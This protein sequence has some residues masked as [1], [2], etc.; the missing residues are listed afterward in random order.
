M[1]QITENL[2]EVN[3]SMINA[4]IN[5]LRFDK[6][7][8]AT[9]VN[10]LDEG[11]YQVFN[12]KVKYQAK[13]LNDAKFLQNDQVYV[14]IKEGDYSLEKTIIGKYDISK[15]EEQI[16]IYEDPFD[17]LAINQTLTVLENQKNK[18]DWDNENNWWKQQE[19][20]SFSITGLGQPTYFG[21]NISLETNS[22]FTKYPE[23]SFGLIVDLI[24]EK[25]ITINS[26]SIESQYIVGN[27]YNLTSD[28]KHKNIY[29]LPSD[30]NIEKVKS[31]T[32]KPFVNNYGDSIKWHDI[33]LY[34]G[35]DNKDERI[36][37]SNDKVFIDTNTGFKMYNTT[38]ISHE[39]FN[40][41]LEKNITIDTAILPQD[42][43][44]GNYNN[45][46]LKKN[47]NFYNYNGNDDTLW[48]GGWQRIWKEQITDEQALNMNMPTIEDNEAF[49]LYANCAFLAYPLE[50]DNIDIN[51]YRNCFGFLEETYTDNTKSPKQYYKGEDKG[52][53]CYFNSNFDNNKS[54]WHQINHELGDN[55]NIRN[56]NYYHFKINLETEEERVDLR[57]KV[58]GPI[59]SDYIDFKVIIKMRGEGA[60][61]S[62]RIDAPRDLNHSNNKTLK[63]LDQIDVAHVLTL[64]YYSK[65]YSLNY[66]FSSYLTETDEAHTQ[67]IVH[68]PYGAVVWLAIKDLG[69][70]N[71]TIQSEY[72]LEDNIV[73]PLT[74]RIKFNH[75]IPTNAIYRND[76]Y[77]DKVG[78]YKVPIED[79]KN[80]STLKY[81]D[82]DSQKIGITNLYE[83]LGEWS[84][85]CQDFI[86]DYGYKYYFGLRPQFG[87]FT[88]AQNKVT[89]P[90][91]Y[92]DNLSLYTLEPIEL[93][94]LYGAW[95]K[96]NNVYS[97]LHIP[98][99]KTTIVEWYQKTPNYAGEPDGI[100][101]WWKKIVKSNKDGNI[102][103]EQDW[104]L[105]VNKYLSNSPS[106][107]FKF[108]V[109]REEEKYIS[110]DLVLT[111]K[112]YIIPR[113]TTTSEGL[114][115][116]INDD[117]IYLYDYTGNILPNEETKKTLTVSAIAGET[118][119]KEND[120][121]AWL[122][123]KNS[124]MIQEPY[125]LSNE[126]EIDGNVQKEYYWE[127]SPEKT[128]DLEPKLE[129]FNSDL[130]GGYTLE[131]LNS[132]YI[133]EKQCTQD[134]LSLTF[135]IKTLFQPNAVNNDILVYVFD[136][137][138]LLSQKYAVSKFTPKF[139][140]TNNAGA[141]GSLGIE[142]LSSKGYL[143]A[144]NTEDIKLK[145]IVYDNTGVPLTIQPRVTWETGG[146][147]TDIYDG[148]WANND[149]GKQINANTI[150]VYKPN[151]QYQVMLKANNYSTMSKA[152]LVDEYPKIY[153][154]KYTKENDSGKM[155][156]LKQDL[157]KQEGNQCLWTDL[158]M[159]TKND[160][161][162]KLG[163]NTI[164][165]LTKNQE[166]IVHYVYDIY[167]K[168]RQINF[169]TPN[170]F[171]TT[172]DPTQEPDKALYICNVYK[173]FTFN[174]ETK[175]STFIPFEYKDNDFSVIKLS[176]EQN[177][178]VYVL[179]EKIKE[180]YIKIAYG[181]SD[182]FAGAMPYVNFLKTGTDTA[183]FQMDYI[184]NSSNGN[185]YDE[186]NISA[187]NNTLILSNKIKVPLI[188]K[189]KC[190]WQRNN[191]QKVLLSSYYTIPYFSTNQKYDLD[192]RTSI[193]YSAF[194]TNPLLEEKYKVYRVT[195]KGRENVDN[196][197]FEVTSI[198]SQIKSEDKMIIDKNGNIVDWR[199]NLS[200]PQIAPAEEEIGTL[201]IYITS[202]WE[203]ESPNSLTKIPKK[204][205][206]EPVAKFPLILYRNS[207]AFKEINEW[208]GASTTVQDTYIISPMIAAG[209][210]NNN[211]QFTGV[212]MGTHTNFPS[213]GLY[214]FKD[215]V[216]TFGFKE[217]GSCFLGANEET[218]RI[219]FNTGG[220]SELTI[221]AKDFRLESNSIL[222]D[223]SNITLKGNT[224]RI[225]F[226][227]LN[228]SNFNFYLKFNSDTYDLGYGI[229]NLKNEFEFNNGQT[230][231]LLRKFTIQF[232]TNY[233]NTGPLLN[234]V[235]AGFI[236]AWFNPF[237][238]TSGYLR[239]LKSDGPYYTLEQ[240][241]DSIRMTGVQEWSVN[242]KIQYQSDGHLLDFYTDTT[243][244][245]NFTIRQGSDGDYIEILKNSIHLPTTRAIYFNS[246]SSDSE[247][248]NYQDG[249]MRLSSAN[250]TSAFT[251]NNKTHY[252]LFTIFG[253]GATVKITTCGIWVY[254]KLV[255]EF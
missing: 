138:N 131:T 249:V 78:I 106:E 61:T 152:L 132:Y 234:L 91:I 179:N 232:N 80:T 90:N 119:L 158:Y 146:A 104:N 223:R 43:Q 58:I 125:L 41:D 153:S 17:R 233:Q 137:N 28:L 213:T 21:S 142:L 118:E 50:L 11:Y 65:N 116:T 109:K 160:D 20:F 29:K 252:N 122:I 115:F 112:G 70:G 18:W 171:N 229:K 243:F 127:C 60:K 52:Y 130:Q 172:I 96:D 225:N 6:T 81:F 88:N 15:P 64:R 147:P 140:A 248:I 89:H 200:F 86:V 123:P 203:K 251:Y 201:D 194:G 26:I 253:H 128:Y 51:Q 92:I 99:D 102:T 76:Y 181:S 185:L 198:N 218:G 208:D 100:G 67:L 2:L 136:G 157:C 246:D 126:T 54:Y 63:V 53:F 210:K 180:V 244:R 206:L 46:K 162:P 237:Q 174:N 83:T 12:G 176:E 145:A 221:R 165:F 241:F 236:E 7:E 8:I 94:T 166:L 199:H 124:T 36:V 175:I 93:T 84:E 151:L 226:E 211:N 13:V 190:E 224:S 117:G 150:E 134:N 139:I 73:Q 57:D 177:R 19:N 183:K 242:D 205:N 48:N 240:S 32:V 35:Y 167:D 87:G 195:N 14:S 220:N 216:A 192:G 68:I 164:Y 111:N 4:S 30:F 72:P 5:N 187:E 191:N 163:N 182:K 79:F 239:L 169:P 77:A 219:E 38:Q 44:D 204:Y 97:K 107:T 114:E 23:A 59:D 71:T 217:D 159:L 184:A 101:P 255:L 66:N 49:H 178:Y 154:I 37:S 222:I 141:E 209:T 197:F 235:G 105:E 47:W 24:D 95:I 207:Y 230:G 148:Y 33:I 69:Y 231:D 227:D 10:V 212:M 120:I 161:Y 155:I 3:Q 135:R 62:L 228:N 42:N 85:Y 238:T 250:S 202:E 168:D 143:G 121:I 254:G 34:F 186:N 173:N 144:D 74:A 39:V 133:I 189:A 16:S 108:V 188:I 55:S 156:Q 214:G 31:I 40:T 196:Y 82:P 149:S 75:F 113:A 27:I 98:T 129:D 103:Y 45:D 170:R 215:G 247:Y 56:G 9:V 1:N 245:N 193:S 110:E 22:N 25:G